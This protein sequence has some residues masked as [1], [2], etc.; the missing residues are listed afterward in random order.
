MNPSAAAYV[1]RFVLVSPEPTKTGSRV[2][3]RMSWRSE[4]SV[5]SPVAVPVTIT[6][7][8]RKNSA[9]RAVSASDTS[10]VIAC[11]ACFFF[12]SA[13]TR[14]RSAPMARR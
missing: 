7:S 4:A 6:P 10:A 1:A 13:N 14:T 11:D 8:A 2:A 3:L 12:K 9:A 5:G